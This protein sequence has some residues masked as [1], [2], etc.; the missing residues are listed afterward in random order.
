MD[1]TDLNDRWS[2]LTVGVATAHRVILPTGKLL[3][4]G[5]T[6]AELQIALLR[7]LPPM[8][9]DLTEVRN[10]F[11]HYVKLLTLIINTWL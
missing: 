3:S 7:E 10:T 4:Y 6:S 1:R 2:L 11:E 8:P 5:G 9:P